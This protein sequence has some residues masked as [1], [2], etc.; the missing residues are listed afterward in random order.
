MDTEYYYPFL[1][2]LAKLRKA[3]ISF[4]MS[5]RRSVRMELGSHWTNL[6]EILYLSIFG[7]SVEVTQVSLKSDKNN[8]YCARR[9]LRHFW[10]LTQFFLEW[11]MFQTT[12][13]EEIKTYILG[14]KFFFFRKSCSLWDYVEKYCQRGR[15]HMTLGRMR[16]ACWITKATHTHTHTH[17]HT[18][19]NTHCFSTTTVARTR[20]NVTLQ[21]TACLA[22]YDSTLRKST[23][24][25]TF[26]TF[27]Q[28]V[29]GLNLYQD[30]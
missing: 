22:R 18:K 13:A 28:G 27:V 6:N 1:G 15:P 4:V 25:V 26:P 5:V 2:A 11:E 21:Y 30:I 9:P 20:L 29:P 24:A 12:V 3:N 7:R 10:Y 14:S 17:T 23:Q 16:I 8:G 19:C